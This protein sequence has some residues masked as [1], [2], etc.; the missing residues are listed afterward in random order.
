MTHFKEAQLAELLLHLNEPEEAAPPLRRAPTR[1]RVA[2]LTAAAAA[3]TALALGAIDWTT[4]QSAY[5]LTKN[6][7]GTFTLTFS[8]R[9]EPATVNRDLREA[10]LPVRVVDDLGWPRPC[11]PTTPEEH[12]QQAATWEA[13]EARQS[14]LADQ[15]VQDKPYSGTAEGSVTIDPDKIPDGGVLRIYQQERHFDDGMRF[16]SFGYQII[17]HGPIPQCQT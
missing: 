16:I 1:R 9:A 8:E 13:W 14:K 17:P 12:A 2:A 11:A 6:D 15:L 7:D 5:A 4:P 10:G 3:A